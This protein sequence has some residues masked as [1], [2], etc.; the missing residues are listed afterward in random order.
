MKKYARIT[1]EQTKCCE[2]GL[3][4]NEKFYQSIGMELC[5]VEQSYNGSW[6]LKGYAPLQPLEEIK[7]LKKQEINT[8]RDA[9]EQGGFAYMGKIFDSDQIS[10]LRISCAAQ[11][12]IHAPEG[13]IITWTCKDNTTID[14][15]AEQLIELMNTLALHSN[16]CHQK[17][18]LLKQAIITATSKEELD[19]IHW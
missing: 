10:C 7:E 14:L 18:N 11:S 9:T 13:T 5:E 12:I 6:Y 19:K 2:V 4:N 8:A 3:G 16:N 15:N 1:N 17:A